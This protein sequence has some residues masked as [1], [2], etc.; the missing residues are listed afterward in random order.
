MEVWILASLHAVT[1]TGLGLATFFCY[2]LSSRIDK[3]IGKFDDK[4]HFAAIDP[5]A[6]FFRSIKE[7]E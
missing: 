3:F 2:K 5:N 1:L 6:V 7:A 4:K